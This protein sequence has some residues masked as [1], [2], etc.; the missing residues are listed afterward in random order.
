MVIVLVAAALNL[1]IILWLTS[2]KND[3]LNYFGASGSN[4]LCN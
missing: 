4:Q 1:H 3:T 2:T